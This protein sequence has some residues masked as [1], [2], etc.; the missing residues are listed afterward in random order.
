MTI[1]DFTNPE[2]ANARFIKF[3]MHFIFEDLL[4]H[5][6][7]IPFNY[8]LTLKYLQEFLRDQQNIIF[9][10]NISMNNMKRLNDN[11]YEFENEIKRHSFFKHHS[12]QLRFITM[13]QLTKLFSSSNSHKRSFHK[14][15]I[16]LKESSYDKSIKNVL[17]LNSVNYSKAIESHPEFPITNDSSEDISFEFGMWMQ[18]KKDRDYYETLFKS[19]NE[20][21][22]EVKV[23]IARLESP[24]ISKIIDKV[25]TCR[26][27]IY[28]HQDPCSMIE[29]VNLDEIEILINEA[30]DIF[31][32]FNTKLLG[33]PILFGYS[34]GG[35]IEY[36]IRRLNLLRQKVND[37]LGKLKLLRESE[38]RK[39]PSDDVE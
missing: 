7:F 19:R 37:D 33:T 22:F 25:V 5:L 15:C 9:D 2:Q 3:H 8:M 31:N 24:S 36:V 13:V 38:K 32:V 34:G 23:L 20:I 30:G 26:D 27:K 10:L 29:Y 18:S 4:M 17:S 12:Y 28:A 11:I 6:H 35:D 39:S 1:L 14:L 16:T 21:L